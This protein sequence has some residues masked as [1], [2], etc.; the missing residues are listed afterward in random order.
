M[1]EAR[2][3]TTFEWLINGFGAGIGSDDTAELG[4]RIRDGAGADYL[5]RTTDGI[6]EDVTVGASAA[7]RTTLTAPPTKGQWWLVADDGNLIVT[8]ELRVTYSAGIASSPT[9]RDLCSIDDVLLYAPGY[10]PDADENSDQTLAVLQA[11]ITE[12]SATQ[13]NRGR[14]FVAIADADPRVFDLTETHVRRRKIRIG[15]ATEIDTVTIVDNVGLIVQ[16]VTEGDWIAHPHVRQEWEPIRHLSFPP[17]SP[18]PAQLDWGWTIEIAATWGFPSIPA[19]VV[20]AVAK[21]VIVHYVTE[22][23]NAGTAFS[24]ALADVNRADLLD[25]AERVLDRYADPAIA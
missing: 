3:G 17:C 1:I 12:E 22:A 20:Q 19:N 4:V 25:S 15:D 6:V 10:D 16:T 23:A 9:G 8:E 5:V 18:S 24:D 14:E 7:Y 21:L 13:L 11:L 2:P